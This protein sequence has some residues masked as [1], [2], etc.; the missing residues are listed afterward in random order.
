[1]TKIY[2]MLADGKAVLIGGNPKDFL[3]PKF[4]VINIDTG[5]FKEYTLE[6]L[7]W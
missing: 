3:R 2:R 1:M 4:H 7:E 5:S 6:D